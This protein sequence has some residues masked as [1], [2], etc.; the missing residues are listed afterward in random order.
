MTSVRPNL[1]VLL[2]SAFVP[3]TW[4]FLL[5]PYITCLPPPPTHPSSKASQA[6]SSFSKLPRSALGTFPGS[7]QPQSH[8]L[9]PLPSRRHLSRAHM[10]HLTF[11][12]PLTNAETSWIGNKFVRSLIPITHQEGWKMEPVAYSGRGSGFMGTWHCP[13]LSHFKWL[14]TTS[15]KRVLS[16]WKWTFSFSAWQCGH[17]E[18]GLSCR[19]S[20]L[21]EVWRAA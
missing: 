12:H 16:Q 20:G 5:E 6:L 19:F 15:P 4:H 10:S 14:R 8:M 2:F 3:Q 9:S 17:G 13:F 1:Q 18:C 11:L 7:A 21:Q